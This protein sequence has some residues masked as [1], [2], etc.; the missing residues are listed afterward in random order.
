[1]GPGCEQSM[2]GFKRYD[3]KADTIFWAETSSFQK[4]QYIRWTRPRRF[5]KC[6]LI[7]IALL[8]VFI[9]YLIRNIIMDE[10]ESLPKD[11][12]N[13]TGR[14]MAKMLPSK[15]FLEKQIN[16][17]SVAYNGFSDDNELDFENWPQ[18]NNRIMKKV[19]LLAYLR[20]G[21]TFLGELFA[22]NPDA[23]YW[24]E[25]VQPMY[26]AFFG[27]MRIPYEI[28]Y[29]TMG[30]QRD[31]TLSELDFIYE[32]LDKFYGCR[33][34]ELPMEMLYQETNN[35]E[36]SGPEWKE[37]HQCIKKETGQKI[38]YHLN[39]CVFKMPAY[40]RSNAGDA[41]QNGCHIVKADLE[42]RKID[43]GTS[44]A[45]MDQKGRIS[46]QNYVSCLQ[47]SKLISAGRICSQFASD[48]CDEA[49]IRAAKVLRLRLE[50]TENLVQKY[51][52]IKIIHQL[53]DPRGVLLSAKSMGLL[54]SFSRGQITKEAILVCDKMLRDIKAFNI[55]KAKYPDNYLQTMYE[56]YAEFP[57]SM[58][59]KIYNFIGVPP[60]DL[61][62]Q[63]IKDL[64]HS[65]FDSSSRSLGAH[66]RNS[67]ET[68][69]KWRT[70]ISV[71]EKSS[72]DE[73]CRDP[74]MAAGYS[75]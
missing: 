14:N 20:G 68:A 33:I 64:T 24:F 21:S 9:M 49:T 72:I 37:Y 12:S 11:V 63:N 25:I 5:G 45:R 40:C 58:I 69:H 74:I 62:R 66:R 19:L 1:M 2:S 16:G 75:L 10:V 54:T 30:K 23:F 44:F 57:M 41:I 53:R 22:S 71:E 73:T 7:A 38:Q 26:Q 39:T 43:N 36:Y 47:T 59:D 15:K 17:A 32:Q 60:S 56:E 27:M 52:D 28:L 55:L 34:G 13:N 18:E 31:Q 29:N 6:Y 3:I 61:L 51:P 70:K 46:V 67:S 48:I 35:Y 50:D 8:Y 65:K 42:G 4:M